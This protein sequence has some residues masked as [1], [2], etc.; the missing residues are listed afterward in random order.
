MKDAS[1]L[2]R[3]GQN[4]ELDKVFASTVLELLRLVFFRFLIMFRFTFILLLNSTI[5]S[6]RII[7]I[8]ASR[9]AFYCQSVSDIKQVL[10]T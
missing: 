3:A 4:H 1:D 5:L 8:F 6:L 7:S 10:T 9:S 2:V